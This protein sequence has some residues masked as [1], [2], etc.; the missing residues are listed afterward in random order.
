MDTRLTAGC[1]ISS[2]QSVADFSAQIRLATRSPTY[3]GARTTVRRRLLTTTTYAPDRTPLL[4]VER[5][6]LRAKI[7]RQRARSC[8]ARVRTSDLCRIVRTIS[9]WNRGFGA[10]TGIGR[11]S[12]VRI[13]HGTG[14]T[15]QAGQKRTLTGTI[16]KTLI[17]RH[18]PAV[19]IR[20]SPHSG[21][22]PVRRA[23]HHFVNRHFCFPV[24][25]WEQTGHRLEN[26]S[27][28]TNRLD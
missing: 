23:P 22:A 17:A 16:A 12:T 10:R 5:R 26:R 27:A 1:A 25:R 9:R 18:G 20:I 14:R 7:T 13:G 11:V 24:K 19:H 4:I 21:Q 2:C 8:G 15:G 28:A 6:G 3:R